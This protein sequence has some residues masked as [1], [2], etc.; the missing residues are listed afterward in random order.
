MAILPSE[1]HVART[2]HSEARRTS[3]PSSRFWLR[4]N[5]KPDGAVMTGGFQLAE[6]S[7]AELECRRTL[8]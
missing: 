3:R 6:L 1:C 8:V 4:P 7:K 2:S 5:Y